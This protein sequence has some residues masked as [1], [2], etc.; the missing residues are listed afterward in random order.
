M[1]WAS[2]GQSQ[3]RTSKRFYCHR[4]SPSAR[5]H[6]ACA[7]DA[8]C[9]SLS[10][11]SV[12]YAICVQ[13]VVHAGAGSKKHLRS[14]ILDP[15]RYIAVLDTIDGEVQMLWCLCI[16]VADACASSSGNGSWD[17]AP[18]A[19]LNNMSRLL[20]TIVSAVHLPPAEAAD[21]LA[22]SIAVHG[23]HEFAR[24][25]HTKQCTHIHRSMTSA[26]GRRLLYYIMCADAA[27]TVK[28]RKTETLHN[29]CSTMGAS[30]LRVC[31]YSNPYRPH[32]SRYV[33]KPGTAQH[34]TSR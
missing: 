25:L 12:R 15:P 22:Y 11:N 4:R 20:R 7:E 21:K 2:A 33:R 18:S 3:L 26:I 28:Y 29:E 23:L 17:A 5:H 13:M 16:D 8:P 9:S 19:T 30:R 10:K 24:T 32:A 31:T 1:S 34:S 27:T 14:N 6:M